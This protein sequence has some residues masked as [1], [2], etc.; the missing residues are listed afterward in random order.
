[1]T[2]QIIDEVDVR[3]AAQPW[4]FSIEN[5]TQIESFWTAAK[6][7][8]PHFFNGIVH[9]MTNWEV[10]NAGGQRRFVG[11][12]ARTDF[13]SFLYWKST[14]TTSACYFDF[15]GAAAILTADGALLM[16]RAG[17]ETLFPDVIEFPSGFVDVED[18]DSDGRM[19]FLS[20]VYREASEE[21]ALTPDQ[22]GKP[23]RH[24]LTHQEEM[25]QAISVFQIG[26]TADECI[27]GWRSSGRSKGAEIASV[28]ALSQ[29][30]QL[31][32]FSTYPHVLAAASSILAE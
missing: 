9:V 11:E 23:V 20:H 30:S 14:S 8:Q 2:L 4:Q 22:I 3:L 13:A 24:L 27:D 25:V 12:M 21:M 17:Q 29:Q 28:M 19:K 1:M 18:F 6:A 5:K 31:S 7:D 15:S 32:A 26:A 16:V 10:R